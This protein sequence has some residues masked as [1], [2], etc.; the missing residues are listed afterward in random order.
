M[1]TGVPVS[2]VEVN[3]PFWVR[4]E[5]RITSNADRIFV[6]NF[7]FHCQDDSC[8][9]ITSAVNAKK[10]PP[11]EYSAECHV[12]ANFLNDGLYSI[13]IALTSFKSGVSIHFDEKGAI[14]LSVRDPIEGIVTRAGYSGGDARCGQA[15]ATVDFE[16]Y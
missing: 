5:Y 7:H 10:L 8:A 9:F 2:D 3:Q 14:M 16:T 12:P 11:G 15:I 6:P 13:R 1:I 4:M